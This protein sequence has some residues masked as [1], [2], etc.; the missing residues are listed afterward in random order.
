MTTDS[1]ALQNPLAQ[2]AYEFVSTRLP[3]N[4]GLMWDLLKSLNLDHDLYLK[5]EKEV[6]DAINDSEQHAFLM[7]FTFGR[8]LDN[9]P[10]FA[11]D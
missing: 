5:L 10:G 8:A 1:I 2:A 4:V 6:A 7:G 11:G 9:V 3:D